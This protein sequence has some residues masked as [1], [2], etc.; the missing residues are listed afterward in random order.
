M[1]IA[2]LTEAGKS[3]LSLRNVLGYRISAQLNRASGFAQQFYVYLLETMDPRPRPGTVRYTFDP[4]KFPDN[5]VPAVKDL[6]LVTGC[7]TYKMGGLELLRVTTGF[8]RAKRYRFWE[9]R[10][11]A[12]EPNVSMETSGEDP[13]SLP[14]RQGLYTARVAKAEAVHLLAFE[15]SQSAIQQNVLRLSKTKDRSVS[16]IKA[17]IDS[18]RGASPGTIEKFEIEISTKQFEVNNANL[19]RLLVEESGGAFLA[20]EFRSPGLDESAAPNAGAVERVHLRSRPG[21]FI[22]DQEGSTFDLGWG[23]NHGPDRFIETV[24]AVFAPGIHSGAEFE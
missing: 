9:L 17:L 12:N 22:L 3:P 10:F 8:T 23:D 19:E 21:K 18:Q 6:E 7:R 5:G 16:W 1:I 20:S 2:T 4:V 15:A 11:G 14:D 13:G 24:T